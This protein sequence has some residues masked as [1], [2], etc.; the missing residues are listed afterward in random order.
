M[1]R[2]AV[3]ISFNAFLF[4]RVLTNDGCNLESNVLHFTVLGART[5]EVDMDMGMSSTWPYIHTGER[6][7]K[8]ER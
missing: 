3:Y 2:L 8:R 1:V 7:R 4:F 5:G 6:D